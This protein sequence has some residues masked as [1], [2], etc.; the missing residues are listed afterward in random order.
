M[1]GQLPDAR[2]FLLESINQL[3]A[4]LAKEQEGGAGA[5][6]APPGAAASSFAPAPASSSFASTS[7]P[8]SQRE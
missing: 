8:A 6:P 1:G 4:K 5:T 3:T 7:P 2:Q